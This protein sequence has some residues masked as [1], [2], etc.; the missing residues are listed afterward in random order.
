MNI[1]IGANPLCWMNKDFPHLGSGYSVEKCVSDISK[2]GYQGLELE[3][4]FMKMIGK[5]PGMLNEKQLLCIGK[6][7]STFILDKDFSFEM[8]R[9]EEHIEMLKSLGAEVVILCE[10]SSAVY[11]D[12]NSPLSKRPKIQSSDDWK[13]LCKGL[14]IMSHFISE[15]GLKSAYHH[16]IGTYIQDEFDID[17]LMN[18]T[19]DLGLLLDTGHLAYAGVDPLIILQ[20][21]ISRI[22]HVHFKSV[23]PKVLSEKLKQ[24][25]SFYSAVVDGVFT[26]PGDKEDGGKE[27]IAFA[28]IANRLK[29]SKYSGWIVM[30]AEQNP[31]IAD[32]YTYA[33]KGFET[34]N[35][36]LT[37]VQASHF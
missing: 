23:R 20:K 12:K 3:D 4:P 29:D 6:W 25:S 35:S 33:S 22:S 11:Q 21:Y 37:T 5:L 1:K 18:N 13:R 17:T 14:E 34:I 9:L 19:K 2:I 32:P 28:D 27:A 31:E 15:S 26:V 7:H 8:K 24:D 10:C 36:L 16:H 30:E